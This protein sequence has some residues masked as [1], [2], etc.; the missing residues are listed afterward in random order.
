MR[1]HLKLWL[2]F[3][4]QLTNTTFCVVFPH[5][6]SKILQGKIHNLWLNV[7]E[8]SRGGACISARMLQ[9]N[10]LLWNLRPLPFVFFC[11]VCLF[12]VVVF[13]ANIH[14]R[15]YD[16]LPS[17]GRALVTAPPPRKKK[18]QKKTIGFKNRA[19]ARLVKCAVES[20]FPGS[21]ALFCVCARSVLQLLLLCSCANG[22]EYCTSFFA[23]LFL[24]RSNRLTANENNLFIRTANKKR[25]TRQLLVTTLPGCTF[26]GALLVTWPKEKGIVLEINWCVHF[27]M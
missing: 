20:I 25:E 2:P 13:F 5:R 17:A 1:N 6:S 24:E 7:H 22:E 15:W 4:T 27:C 21:M 8:I 23:P 11:F 18:N 26:F 14:F 9:W 19:I 16:R 10:C 12:V 3:N